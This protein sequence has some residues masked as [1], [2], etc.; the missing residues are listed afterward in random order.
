M[1][2]TQTFLGKP[3]ASNIQITFP[4][5][6]V[7]QL[8]ALLVES[9][10]SHGFDDPNSSVE[11]NCETKLDKHYDPAYTY[12]KVVNRNGKPVEATVSKGMYT[13]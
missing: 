2:L 13:Y 9:I 11:E 8:P 1:K 3:S 5:L 7:P 6:A 12:C 10:T 4:P